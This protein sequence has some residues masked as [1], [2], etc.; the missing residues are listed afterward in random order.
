MQATQLE[1]KR[2]LAAEIFC[3][4]MQS[5]ED[6]GAF[7]LFCL[8][9]Q[10]DDISIY[11]NVPTRRIVEFYGKCRDGLTDSDIDTIYGVP[12]MQTLIRSSQFAVSHRSHYEVGMARVHKTV[13]DDFAMRGALFSSGYN[14]STQKYDYSEMANMYFN[15]KHGVRVFLPTPARA[16]ELSL[17]DRVVAI[18][19]GVPNKGQSQ[20]DTV[21]VGSFDLDCVPNLVQNIH[22]TCGQ[23]EALATI[24]LGLRDDPLY[25]LK[26]L[27]VGTEGTD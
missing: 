22:E 24:R 7:C 20:S 3:K 27:R 2:L 5:T 9:A 4:L 23:L 18:L 19:I 26:Y 15:A 16:Q 25:L 10:Q 6:L 8:S 17:S 11:F 21:E 13:R 14:K 1:K 12:D